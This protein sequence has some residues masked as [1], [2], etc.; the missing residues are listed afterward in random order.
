MYVQKS[1]GKGMLGSFYLL[2]F[3]PLCLSTG[4][5]CKGGR[6]EILGEP[7]FPVLNASPIIFTSKIHP[8]LYAS[9]PVTFATFSTTTKQ[10]VER[11][12]GRDHGW[13]IRGDAF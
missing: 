3:V 9:L 13:P 4:G 10:H 1:L 7:W 8:T 6:R 5:F 11:R 12:D 2:L